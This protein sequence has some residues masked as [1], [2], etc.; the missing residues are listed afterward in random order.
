MA[1]AT[2]PGTPPHPLITT[3][4]VRTSRGQSEHLL[5]HIVDDELR[6]DNGTHVHEP[7]P[8]AHEELP[9]PPLLVQGADDGGESGGGGILVGLGQDHVSGLGAEAG[10][11]AVESEEGA[12]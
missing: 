6:R 12:S 4:S 2:M 5:N 11:D 8:R 10:E 1:W 7:A 3:S 9:Q